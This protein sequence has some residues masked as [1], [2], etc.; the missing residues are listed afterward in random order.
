M[1]HLLRAH[2]CPVTQYYCN[3]GDRVRI[4]FCDKS[5]KC[6]AI[7]KNE[8]LELFLIVRMTAAWQQQ[9]AANSGS[10]LCCVWYVGN[11][12][13]ASAFQVKIDCDEKGRWQGAA[14][15]LECTGPISSAVLNNC[16]K[17]ER[18]AVYAFVEIHCWC[19]FVLLSK[20]KINYLIE[21]KFI[22][23]IYKKLIYL[24]YTYIYCEWI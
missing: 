13:G 3:F 12:T 2:Q 19:Y 14:M 18:N 20:N 7:Q 10:M 16:A 17:I 8:K 11:E 15:S 23:F 6:I 9:D 1:T 5:I 22:Y 4:Q 21:F 24:L